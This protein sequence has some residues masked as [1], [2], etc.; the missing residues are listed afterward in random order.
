MDVWYYGINLYRAWGINKILK[1]SSNTNIDVPSLRDK[2]DLKGFVKHKY[3]CI[4]QMEI[5]F[6]FFK[7]HVHKNLVYNLELIQS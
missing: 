5:E 1:V 3:W 2:K 7:K 6:F 4:K